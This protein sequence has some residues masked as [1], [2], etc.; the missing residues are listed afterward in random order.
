VVGA[1]ADGLLL[2]PKIRML[3]VILPH[4]SPWSGAKLSTGTTLLFT[5]S[6]RKMLK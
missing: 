5:L 6:N 3:G 4:T 1:G 2:V